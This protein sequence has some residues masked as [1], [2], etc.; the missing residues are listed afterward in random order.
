MLSKRVSNIKIWLRIIV[1]FLSILP[2]IEYMNRN[3]RPKLKKQNE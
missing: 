1:K 3:G 2:N